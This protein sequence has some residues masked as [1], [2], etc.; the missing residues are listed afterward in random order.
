MRRAARDSE[1]TTSGVVCEVLALAANSGRRWAGFLWLLAYGQVEQGLGFLRAL[2]GLLPTQPEGGG[3][4][5]G[6]RRRPGLRGSAQGGDMGLLPQSAV[7][8]SC[9]A[10]GS[11]LK[12]WL[13]HSEPVEVDSSGSGGGSSGGAAL[14]HAPPPPGHPRLQLLLSHAVRL[15]LPPL[16]RL[17]R[18]HAGA[19]VEQQQQ[20]EAL[21]P[22]R[23]TAGV[24]APVLAWVLAL[25]HV[26][27][28]GGSGSGSGSGS[29]DSDGVGGSA[30]TPDQQQQ[31]ALQAQD[32]ALQRF[33]FEELGAV[34]LLG[35]VLR[36]LHALPSFPGRE[37]TL[38]R[39]LCLLAAAFPHDVRR[40]CTAAECPQGG[41]GSSSSSAKGGAK[42]RRERGAPGVGAG[43]RAGASFQ[44]GSVWPVALVRTL[45]AEVD[46]VEVEGLAAAIEA[47]AGLLEAWG[48][49]RG[50]QEEEKGG[51]VSRLRA[52]VELLD[53]GGRAPR[54]RA[55][56]L[57]EVLSQPTP[58]DA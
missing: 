48:D 25:C 26:D 24:V 55:R 4:G 31:G 17:V 1:G 50:V 39:A 3:G 13:Q 23:L 16:A 58:L 12:L 38:A 29:G 7:M 30:Y 6:G 41:S 27:M 2:R 49:G 32:C 21:R 56:V 15:L 57:L 36:H 47:L 33:L 52:A 9:M 37:V 44:V 54:S 43:A 40:R 42:G 28:Q 18:G 53:G 8:A 5:G 45:G 34:E 10:A 20:N 22:W 19:G 35:A 14:P 11:G 46:V 51:E